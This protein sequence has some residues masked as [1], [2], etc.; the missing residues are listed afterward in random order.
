MSQNNKKL[1]FKL[2][3]RNNNKYQISLNKKSNK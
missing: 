2:K 1:Q 3:L